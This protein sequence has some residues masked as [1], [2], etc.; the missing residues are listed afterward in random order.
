MVCEI[1]EISEQLA[2]AKSEVASLTKQLD[3]TEGIVAQVLDYDYAPSSMSIENKRS[4]FNMSQE[5]RSDVD[6]LREEEL[7]NGLKLSSKTFQP[8]TCY[9]ISEKGAELVGKL[10]KSDRQLYRKWCLRLARRT[11]CK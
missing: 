3:T 2:S 6:F 10:S 4:Y 1:A 9:Q 8:T 7:L 5:G 11:C